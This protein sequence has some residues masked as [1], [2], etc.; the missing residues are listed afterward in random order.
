M[1]SPRP[2]S[3]A[4][5]V[6]SMGIYLLIQGML[7]APGLGAEL[8]S[9]QGEHSTGI[10]GKV[11]DVYA[12]IKDYQ[13]ETEVKVYHEGQVAETER[14]LYTFKKPNHIRIDMKSPYAGMILIYPGDDSKVTVK[15]V[16][17]FGF[18]KLHLSPDSTLLRTATGQRI[19]Q[20]DMGL[21][22]QNIDHSLTDRRHGEIRVFEKD[23]QA[24]IEVLAEDH[25][26][27]GV[28]T[29]YHFFIDKTRWLPAEVREFTPNGITKRVVTFRNLRTS[30]DIPESFFQINGGRPERG[31]SNR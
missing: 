30:I 28:L 16:G 3:G 11:K 18:L 14:F 31:Q 6:V 5:K 15:R 26:L 25:F 24:R 4:L 19:D 27:A 7:L 20:T 2:Y 8:S 21:L 29:L 13:M 22:I 10:I 17:L 23:G 12:Q 1:I 9:P